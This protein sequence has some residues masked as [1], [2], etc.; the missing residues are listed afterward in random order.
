[1][2]DESRVINAPTTTAFAKAD[3]EYG[4]YHY[5]GVPE[6]DSKQLMGASRTIKIPGTL[7]QPE[8]NLD[9]LNDTCFLTGVE[10][11]LEGERDAMGV[12]V[13]ADNEWPG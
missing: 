10:G 1:M 11:R 8:R 4:V 3:T 13:N 2:F 5:R 6:S 9:A 7:S 12:R